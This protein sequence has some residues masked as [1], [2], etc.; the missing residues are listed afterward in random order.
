MKITLLG[1]TSKDGQ[2]PT[3]YDTDRDT[4]LVQGWRV[5]DPEALAAMTMPL[6]HEVVTDLELVARHAQWMDLA[7]AH[8][9]PYADYLEQDPSR[10]SPTT[11]EG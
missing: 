1:T 6:A 3:L 11:V 4:Y 7:M 5:L 10:E 8:A 9:T 2:S